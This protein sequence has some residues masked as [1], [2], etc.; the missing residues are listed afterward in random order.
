MRNY[1]FV[2][3]LRDGNYVSVEEFLPGT[4]ANCGCF[5]PE[6]GKPVRSEEI[7]A[8]PGWVNL[9]A[10][11]NSAIHEIPGDEILQ[12]GFRL[13]YGYERIKTFMN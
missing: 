11:R 4:G 9:T 5:C 7:V 10:V 6:C 8:R 3:A 2:W 1:F 13:V 12:P